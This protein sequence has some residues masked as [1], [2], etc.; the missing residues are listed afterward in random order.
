VLIDPA[1]LTRLRVDVRTLAATMPWMLRPTSSRSAA[2]VR[3]MMAP[4]AQVDPMQAE[5]MTLVAHHCRSTLAPPPLSPAV[6]DR[7][8]GRVAV[9]SGEFDCFLPPARLQTAVG[10]RLGVDLTVVERA[11]HLLPEESPGSVVEVV[12]AMLGE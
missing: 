8:R 11:G 10:D 6:V 3:V 4:G 12:R 2:L 7:W 5:W 9:V 1:G